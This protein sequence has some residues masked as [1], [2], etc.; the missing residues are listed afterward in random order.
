M[1][2]YLVELEATDLIEVRDVKSPEEA[3]EAAKDIFN[4]ATCDT[5][6]ARVVKTF[7]DLET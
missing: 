1:A 5:V 3:I 7:K 4:L 6:S 2:A